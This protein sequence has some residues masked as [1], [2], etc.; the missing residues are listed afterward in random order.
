M[1]G[2]GQKAELTWMMFFILLAPVLSDE[3]TENN[4]WILNKIRNISYHIN[5][6]DYVDAFIYYKGLYFIN[7]SIN[8]GNLHTTLTTLYS[9]LKPNAFITQKTFSNWNPT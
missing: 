4:K 7:N 9:K 5:W 3:G 6:T 2:C 1:N 8:T